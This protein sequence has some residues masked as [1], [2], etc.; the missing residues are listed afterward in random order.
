MGY[1]NWHFFRWVRWND[2]SKNIVINSQFLQNV[3]SHTLAATQSASYV[4]CLQIA[5]SLSMRK[6]SA[7]Y[8]VVHMNYNIEVICVRQNFDW[9]FEKY[10]NIKVTA[11]S[12]YYSRHALF[13]QH[14]KRKCSWQ[15]RYAWRSAAHTRSDER[16]QKS[17][18]QSENYYCFF[19]GH[20]L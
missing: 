14:S 4:V 3:H 12:E 19:Y 11:R 8:T 13:L 9:M 6:I 2:I 10:L 15:N 18:E 7:P 17:F 16:W 5:R 20:C 1:I